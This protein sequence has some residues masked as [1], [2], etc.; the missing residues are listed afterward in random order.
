M[1]I[2]VT[3][4]GKRV[5]LIKHLK[6]DN[7]II[8]ADA[9]SDNACREFVDVFYEI[10]KY[11]EKNYLD[12]LLEIC[13]KEEV[14]CL[15]PLYEGEFPV[16]LEN[17]DKFLSIGTVL[18]VSDKKIVELFSYKQKVCEFMKANNIETPEVYYS[19]DNLNYPL[20]VKP[21]NGMG[22]A[23]VFKV[24]NQRE[25]EF[26]KD[27]VD[28]SI[29]QEFI[30][31]TE[32]TVDVLC[33]MRGN[34]IYIIPRERVEVRSGEVSKSR[35]VKD[36]ELVDETKKIIEIINSNFN[37]GLRGPL[38]FQF[39]KNEDKLYFLELNTRFGGGVPLSFE[40]G[41]NYSEKLSGII[42][43][44]IFD[45]IDS[46]KEVSMCRYDDAVYR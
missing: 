42:D 29:V 34:C 3:A 10:P 43:G 41:A 24:R 7:K 19:Y 18:L 37:N 39:I 35:T 12:K 22:S 38:T 28:N 23:G 21:D 25:L 40:A 32:Y 6:Q 44:K 16:L 31:G 17:K 5:G 9:S 2:L 30:S 20:I 36:N 4:I 45:Y 26:F 13:E 11:N 15:I 1:N 33:D 46:Y 8:G 14:K 27:Y